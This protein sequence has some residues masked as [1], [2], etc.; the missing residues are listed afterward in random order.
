MD[1]IKYMN[2][3]YDIEVSRAQAKYF[4]I[5]VYSVSVV[6]VDKWQCYR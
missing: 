6:S 2:Y 1:A 4:A 3:D 5:A